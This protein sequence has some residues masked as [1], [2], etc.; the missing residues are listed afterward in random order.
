MMFWETASPEKKKKRD[1]SV[2]PIQKSDFSCVSRLGTV[3]SLNN[4]FNYADSN[5][6]LLIFI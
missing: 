4:V 6:T 1:R 2:L 3:N 5:E